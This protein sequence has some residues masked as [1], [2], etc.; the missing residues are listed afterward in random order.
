MAAQLPAYDS[1]DIIAAVL[2]GGVA[3]GRVNIQ[4]RDMIGARRVGMT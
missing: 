4:V 3:L 2:Q 1:I